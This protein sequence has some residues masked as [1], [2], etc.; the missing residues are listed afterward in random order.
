M[1]A[2]PLMALLVE[3][4]AAEYPLGRRPEQEPQKQAEVVGHT[5][6]ALK[7]VLQMQAPKLAYMPIGVDLQNDLR[8]HTIPMQVGAEA[9]V[10]PSRVV[11]A[12]PPMGPRHIHPW[13]K[14][15]SFLRSRKKSMLEL[16]QLVSL[17]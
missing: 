14:S 6:R 12:Y 10:L 4:E 11:P 2:Q 8:C 9:L 15:C 1:S 5:W 13:R 7:G 16:T 17:T 3:V